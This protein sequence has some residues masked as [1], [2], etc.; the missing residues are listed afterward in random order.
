MGMFGINVYSEKRSYLLFFR[1]MSSRN[2]ERDFN[3]SSHITE[4]FPI[5]YKFYKNMYN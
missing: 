4:S 2:P 1:S 3:L 5:Y